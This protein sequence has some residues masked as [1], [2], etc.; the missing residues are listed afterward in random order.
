[1]TL[2]VTDVNGAVDDDTIEIAVTSNPNSD[3]LIAAGAA[4]AALAAAALVAST[5]GGKLAAFQFFLFPLYARRKRDELLDQENRGMIRGY[6]LVHPGDSYSD[7]RRNLGLSNGTLSYHLTVL[8]REGIIQSQTRGSRKLFFPREARLPNDGGGMHEVQLRMLRAVREI[9]G[10]AVTDLAGALGISS[11][12]ALY[13]LRDL[14]AKGRIRFE[15]RGL[16][17][18]C[19][20][21]GS[22]PW[23]ASLDT[24]APKD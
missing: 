17:L 10:L 22:E 8:E 15:R 21:E 11:Q 19:Y 20:A 7:I 23:D 12:L 18:R 24:P 14:A 5:E 1:V 4:G 9:P 13:H 6:L 16:R 2:F 3:G